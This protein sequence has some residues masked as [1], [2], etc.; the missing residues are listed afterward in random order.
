MCIR[1]KILFGLVF[2]IYVFTIVGCATY[3]P[4]CIPPPLVSPDP[5][6]QPELYAQHLE[7]QAHY[8]ACKEAQEALKKERRLL[9]NILPG[10]M[11]IRVIFEK[12]I[13]E[14]EKVFSN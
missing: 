5:V 3:S 6:R 8:I 7:R 9:L 1:K 2:V 4:K 13:F 12:I 10:V 14:N 11:W